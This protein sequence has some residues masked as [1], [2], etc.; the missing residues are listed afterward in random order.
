MS[1]DF[2]PM[3]EEARTSPDAI[4][5]AV[6][7]MARAKPELDLVH[8]A[9]LAVDP[10]PEADRMVEALLFASAAPVTA[11]SIAAR[12]PEGTDVGGALARLKR[13]YVGRGVVLVEVAGGWRFQTAPDLAYLMEERREEPKK[14]SRAALET[15]AIIAYHQPCTR[16]EIEEV[17]GVAVGRGTLDLL[18]EIGW[19]RAGVRRQSPGKPLTYKTT[20]DFLSH[21][22]LARLDDLP[23]KADLQAQGLLDSRLPP[24]FEVP[25]PMASPDMDDDNGA[26]DERDDGSD[27]TKDFFEA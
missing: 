21:F 25:R 20:A 19:V 12:L 10:A 18:M 3:S 5:K 17:R 1:E 22:N 2:E 14:L 4:S 23:G 24:D 16:S 7:A 8:R 26:A 15:L 11:L 13:R 6:R 27:F 9:D